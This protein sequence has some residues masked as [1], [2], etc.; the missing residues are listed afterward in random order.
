MCN[1]IGQ[2]GPCANCT[3]LLQLQIQ[4]HMQG[5]PEDL[6]EDMERA[7]RKG[8]AVTPVPSKALKSVPAHDGGC[9]TCAFDR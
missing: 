5:L 4:I 6:M 3:A 8:A 9:F 2:L 1:F 7:P